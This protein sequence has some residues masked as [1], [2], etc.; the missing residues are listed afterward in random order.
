MQ[1]PAPSFRLLASGLKE[2]ALSET[3]HFASVA[4]FEG[5]RL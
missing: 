4:V 3:I 1:L 5:A 2:F